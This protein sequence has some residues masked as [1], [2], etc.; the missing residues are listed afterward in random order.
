MQNLKRVSSI[1]RKYITINTWILSLQK[2]AH[3]RTRKFSPKFHT[4]VKMPV[5]PFDASKEPIKKL[6]QDNDFVMFSLSKCPF[7]HKAKEFFKNK[8]LNPIIIEVDQI[9]ESAHLKATLFNLTGQRTFPNIFGMSNHLGGCD[10]VLFLEKSGKFD[11]AMKVYKERRSLENSDF[12]FEYDAVLIGG[13]SGGLA[14]A[15]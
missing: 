15:K 6:I 10:D 12:T 5:L 3:F 1:L 11:N 8:S 7:C 4:F 2:S 9:D 13:G 14:C